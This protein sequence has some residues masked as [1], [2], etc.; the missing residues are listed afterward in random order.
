MVM[1]NAEIRVGIVGLDTSH[2]AQFTRLLN[3]PHTPFHVP[4]ARVTVA[5]PGGSP[6]FPLSHSRIP[7]FRRVVEAEC[8]VTIVET[9]EAVVEAA[10]VILLESV[11]GR[12]HVE[13]FR[14]IA[15]S[16]KPVFIDKPLAVSLRDADAIGELAERYR[17]PLFSTSAVRYAESLEHALEGLG[18]VVLGADFY[19]PMP[20]QPPVPG[21]FWYGI[22]AVEMLYRAMG[23]GCHEVEA[24]STPQSDLLVG[25]W[26]DGRIGT[27]R[28]NRVGNAHF[29]G[30]V[31]GSRGVERADLRQD[32]EPYYARLL[33]QI[34]AM[35]RTGV[36]PVPFSE[37]REVVRFLEA[38][39]ESRTTGRAVALGTGG[40]SC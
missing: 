34:V 37:T 18:E 16:G 36:V 20:W 21:W 38:A 14:R 31:H 33:Q 27:A 5:Y 3:D 24:F 1:S 9:I 10:D 29:G 15:P 7:E 6:D 35:G 8:G 22:H 32:Q 28:G 17:V 12:R 23:P 39:N 25:L 4:G 26:R 19:G 2:A 13:E 11:D 40:A 30:L